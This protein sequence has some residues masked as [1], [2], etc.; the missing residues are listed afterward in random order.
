MPEDTY[1]VRRRQRPGL[2]RLGG[3]PEALSNRI[4]LNPGPLEDA[5]KRVSKPR[6]GIV[7]LRE[8][9][10]R[11]AKRTLAKTVTRRILG[12]AVP[13]LGMLTDLALVGKASVEGYK[14]FKAAKEL[15]DLESA[16]K[17]KRSRKENK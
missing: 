15:R 13:V 17:K 5:P 3:T 7:R 1:A 11:I 12:R 14:A 2:K 6:A 16:L 10:Q 8:A 9:E 4:K